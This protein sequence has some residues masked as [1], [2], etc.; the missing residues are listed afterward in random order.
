M[1]YDNKGE[2]DL[3]IADYNKVI[4]LSQDPDLVNEAKSLIQELSK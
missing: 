1:T 3:A 2:Y 4:E